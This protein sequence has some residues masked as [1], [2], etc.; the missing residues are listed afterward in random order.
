MNLQERIGCLAR[1]GEYMLGD[2]DEWVMTKAR[3][4]EVNAWFIPEFIDLAVKNIA[5]EF[6]QQEKLQAWANQYNT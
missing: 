2:D 6:L 1:L 5:T 4:Y 3:A